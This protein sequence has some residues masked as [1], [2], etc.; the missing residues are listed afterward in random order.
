MG[1]SL[2]HLATLV[3]TAARE[4]HRD[5][6]RERLHGP[7]RLREGEGVLPLPGLPSDLMLRN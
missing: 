7:R 5:H 3:Q 2:D 4:V 6:L 1:I